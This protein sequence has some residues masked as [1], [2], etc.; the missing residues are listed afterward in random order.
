MSAL[1]QARPEDVREVADRLRAAGAELERVAATARACAAGPSWVGLAAL[2]QAARAEAAGSLVAALV[3]PGEEAARILGGVAT[4]TE[5]A[6]AETAR[7]QRRGEELAEE[8]VHLRAAV[9]TADP[10]LAPVVASRIEQLELE[11]SRVRERVEATA[12]EL[13]RSLVLAARAVREAAQ[14]LRTALEHLVTLGLAGQKLAKAHRP[15]RRAV[16]AA[17]GLSTMARSRWARDPRAREAARSRLQDA[18]RR[19]AQLRQGPAPGRFVPPPLRGPTAL[20]GRLSPVWTW[21]GALADLRDGGGDQGW[22]GTTTRVVA[23]GAVLGVPALA[24]AAVLPPVGLAGLVAVGAY[25]AWTTGSWLYDHRQAV[26]RAIGATLARVREAGARSARWVED[27]GEAARGRARARAARG[28]RRLGQ[29]A[30]QVTDGAGRLG[31][32]AGRWVVEAQRLGRPTV[33]DL[34]IR[35]GRRSSVLPLRWSW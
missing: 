25:T 17:A 16:V 13:E 1:V 27:A 19:W 8:L 11:L 26:G 7:W 14:P 28:L 4:A 3:A 18:S 33:P 12:E 23:G 20:L 29:I 32:A 15:V 21:F 34:P 35:S 6:R 22:R 31:P 24:L 9:P 10:S 5:Q 30:G 2:E